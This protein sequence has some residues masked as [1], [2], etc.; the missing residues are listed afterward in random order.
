MPFKFKPTYRR[1]LDI[2]RRIRAKEYPNAPQLARDWEVLERAIMHDIAFMR[3]EL[4]AP[5][6][7]SAKHRGFYYDKPNWFL[8][9]IMVSEGE[10]LGILLGQQLI[11]T[12]EGTP[13]AKD[14]K[15]RFAK[16]EAMLPDKIA[17]RP[18]FI[19]SRFT[20][21]KP[22]TRPIMQG[23]WLSI[24]RATIRQQ[25]ATISYR[26]PASPRAK[27]HVIHP[28]HVLNLEGEW[29]VLAHNAR[30]E[31]VSQFAIGR[32]QSIKLSAHKFTIPSTFKV[33]N[34]LATRFGRYIHHGE[35]KEP[36]LVKLLIVPDLA[37]W[38]SEKEW[39]PKQKL[40]KRKSGAVELHIPVTDT[41]DIESW[42]LSLGEHVKVLGPNSLKQKVEER[43]LK[44]VKS[45]SFV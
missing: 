28:Y 9:S 27:Q 12:Y 20:F 15:K 1:V 33:K 26:S 40:I 21:C 39:H 35:K 8:P 29:Y 30:H 43:H 44:A 14:L 45:R 13:V 7:Y 25:V 17:I 3:N 36:I 37:P 18:E 32:I 22:P 31:S 19:Q 34:V 4:G 42:I 2:D 10:V 38:A 5:I 41:R 6:V 11:E 23:I 16:M 24:I